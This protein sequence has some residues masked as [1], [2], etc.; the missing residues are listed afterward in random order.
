LKN[1][2]SRL[3][4][5]NGGISIGDRAKKPHATSPTP[6]SRMIGFDKNDILMTISYNS[7]KAIRR[8]TG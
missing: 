6:L 4:P 2:I 7:L 1:E 8:I 3:L 5:E